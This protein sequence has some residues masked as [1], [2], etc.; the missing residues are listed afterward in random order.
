MDEDAVIQSYRVN[1]KPVDVSVI[2]VE[3][4]FE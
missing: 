3:R 4:V 2:P 1:V